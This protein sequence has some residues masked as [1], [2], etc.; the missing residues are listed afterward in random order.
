MN[1]RYYDP[2]TGRFIS[3]DT[4]RGDGEEFWHLYMYCDGDPVNCTDPTGHYPAR[5]LYKRINNMIRTRNRKGNNGVTHVAIYIGNNKTLQC[6]DCTTQSGRK[7]NS[8]QIIPF[9]KYTQNSPYKNS[10]GE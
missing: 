9:P 2:E 1:A 5:D 6:N 3:K 10:S 8:V 4:Y 7:I